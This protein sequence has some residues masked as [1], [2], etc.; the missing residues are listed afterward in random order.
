M[1]AWAASTAS[2]HDGEGEEGR[3]DVEGGGGEVEACSQPE[4]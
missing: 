3:E 1:G 4:A 2:A